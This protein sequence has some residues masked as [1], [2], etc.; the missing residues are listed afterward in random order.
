MTGIERDLG[1]ERGEGGE[2]GEGREKRGG[3]GRGGGD[4]GGQR[5]E[6]GGGGGGEV[7]EEEDYHYNEIELKKAL[8]EVMRYC[9]NS[10]LSSLQRLWTELVCS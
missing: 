3:G 6:G 4:R 9:G 5:R 7:K 10:P 8:M 1:K 2:G